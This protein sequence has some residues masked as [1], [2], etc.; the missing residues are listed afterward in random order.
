LYGVSK[1]AVEAL[2]RLYADRFGMTVVSARLGTVLDHPSEVRHLST[3]ASPADIARLVDAVAVLDEPGGHV[4]WGVSANT[5]NWASLEAGRSLGYAPQDD[6][7][8][9]AAQLGSPPPLPLECTLAGAFA[10]SE[11]PLG[12]TW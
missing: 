5:R 4:I 2:G 9:F 7:E 3:W 12:G 6:A 11:H 1:V 8:D 10:D